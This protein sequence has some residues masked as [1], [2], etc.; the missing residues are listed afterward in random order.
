MSTITFKGVRLSEN[1]CIGMMD[2]GN[3]RG[4]FKQHWI[5]DY[6]R[7]RVMRKVKIN[8]LV[9]LFVEKRPVDAIKL[10][11]RGAVNET[12]EGIFELDADRGHISIIDG[13]QR[14]L[15]AL[16]SGVDDYQ[17]P[18]ELHF[19]L[20][21]EREVN[22]FWQFNHRA[23][24]LQSAELLK[25]SRGPYGH[26]LRNLTTYPTIP[27]KTV[28][29]AGNRQGIS[30]SAQAR[31]IYTI[32]RAIHAN[33]VLLYLASVTQTFKL[34]DEEVPREQVVATEQVF[35]HLWETFVSIFGEF[36]SK[37][38]A[39][40]GAVHL[41]MFKVFIIHFLD[42]RTHRLNFGKLR[43]RVEQ[44]PHF[45]ATSSRLKEISIS[46]SASGILNTE[47]AIVEFLNYRLT[48]NRLINPEKRMAFYPDQ[49]RQ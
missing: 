36:D 2:L 28:V 45:F 46:G 9:R 48:S 38:M 21:R 16:D 31:I 17:L 1:Y 22:L 26:L 12:A 49:E 35:I 47:R 44:L 34:L 29:R 37:A 15:A 24:K 27:V 43:T 39:Y 11:Y 18:V 13:Q 7:E 19:D 4:A 8:E 41:A 14:V 42:T 5:P 33:E 40:R 6:Q 23:T 30:L 10:N 3:L 20:S 32:H 25:S